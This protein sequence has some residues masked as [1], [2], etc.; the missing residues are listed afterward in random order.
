MFKLLGKSMKPR[1]WLTVALIFLLTVAQVYFMM[2]IV[3]YL[4]FPGII[5]S[6]YFMN[7]FMVNASQ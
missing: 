1:D 2:Q 3:N 4:K 5:V 6:T 7:R